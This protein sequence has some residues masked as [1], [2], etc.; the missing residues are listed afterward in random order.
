V[1]HLVESTS[2][3]A[4][5]LARAVA[6]VA[7]C[8][9]F[10][11]ACG[12]SSSGTAAAT[13][14]AGTTAAGTSS[15]ASGEVE[16]ITATEADFSISLDEDRLSAGTYDIKVVNKGESTHDLVVEQDGKDVAASDSI[17]PGGSTTLTVT[18]A[19]GDYV[20]Y[21]SIDNHR[22]MGMETNVSVS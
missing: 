15:A 19:P 3:L 18:L 16:S 13:T 11:T 6:A 9:A 22:S 5:R 17:G 21:C 1:S 8:A 10:L 20:F 12:G 4:R 7:I 2:L 14:A